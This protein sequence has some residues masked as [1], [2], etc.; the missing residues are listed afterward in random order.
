MHLL[1]IHPTNLFYDSNDLSGQVTCGKEEKTH[2]N[3][4]KIV[5]LQVKAQTKWGGEGHIPTDI[6]MAAAMPAI[7][8]ATPLLQ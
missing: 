7:L 3:I 8:P 1:F 4:V 5:K 2:R 6:G